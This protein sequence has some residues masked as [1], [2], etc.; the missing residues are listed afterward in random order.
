MMSKNYQYSLRF[1]LD[2]INW[3]ALKEEK[4]LKFCE[5]AHIDNVVFFIN[6]EEINQ[7]HQT[8]PQI[9]EWLSVI[10]SVSEH[11]KE[12]SICTSLNPWT[13]L[14][15]S[16]RGHKVNPVLGFGTMVDY[17]GI[18]ADSIACPADPRWKKYIVDAYRE[19]AELK[20][21]ELWLEDDFRHYK[22]TPLKLGC[23]CE[24]HMKIYQ[25][26]LGKKETRTEFVEAMLQTG[27]PTVERK[28]YLKVA[29]QEMKEVAKEIEKAVQF[30]SPET[31]LGLMSSFPRWH[32]VEGRDWQGLFD[33]LSGPHKRV[34]RPH[35][36]AYNE[37]SPLKYARDFEAIT[38]VTAQFVGPKADVFPE[39]ENYM[40]SPFVKSKR[41]TQFQL[42]STALVGANGI[43]LNLFDMMGNGIDE[44]Y[45]YQK[46]LSESK[47]FMDFS[48][49][50]RLVI[51]DLQGIKVLIDQDSSNTIHTSDG[52]DPSELLPKED[53]WLSLL[54]SLGIACYPEIHVKGSRY[55]DQVI[56]ISGQF[57]RNLDNDSIKQ[58]LIKNTVLMDGESADIL[59]ER[60]LQELISAK[61]GKW[62]KARTDYQSYEQID[63][64]TIDGIE[65]PRMT[66][67]QHMGDYYQIEYN[68]RE[69]KEVSSAR[70]E[71]GKKLGSMLTE[72]K[73]HI[74]VLPISS[75]SKYGWESQYYSIREKI[76]K[77][78][79][80]R[81]ADPLYI[82]GMPGTK[83]VSDS[84]K[85]VISNFTIDDYEAIQ[86]RMP[87]D[88]LKKNW[89]AYYREGSSVLKY[90]IT[91]N[92]ILGERIL[93]IPIK[94]AG[95]E[96]LIINSEE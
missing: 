92:D 65:N 45:D 91:K 84:K 4:L 54:G 39:L 67:L 32:S 7:G 55:I 60:G 74:L 14:M 15:H 87:K 44:T 18:K 52:S 93:R 50:N 75:D 35:L 53:S 46:I 88:M 58:L 78:E 22:H 64:K 95:L 38:R 5:D 20:P 9:H 61:T 69:V 66:M 82:V 80:R 43:L 94:L 62:M 77:D 73:N 89:T 6:S 3:D 51:D 2:P 72:V 59:F 57:L 11:L 76:L 79:L 27:E 86:I 42:E 24:R 31:R 96:T 37:V 47:Q 30:V 71:Y 17:Q 21:K 8:I 12:R 36:P 1:A 56:A 48:A 41:F 23:F 19:F 63:G 68:S 49:K 90:Q 40:Y 70:N 16:D 26:Q 81:V 85:M 28:V 25:E 33:N 13:T 29:R 34:S 10:K 83:I